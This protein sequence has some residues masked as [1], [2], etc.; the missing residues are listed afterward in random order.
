[1]PLFLCLIEANALYIATLPP[2]RYVFTGQNSEYLNRRNRE[3]LVTVDVT[4]V[5]HSCQLYHLQ[6]NSPM[7][8]A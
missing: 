2:I 8:M 3:R 1:M 6:L 7:A 5:R 4:L